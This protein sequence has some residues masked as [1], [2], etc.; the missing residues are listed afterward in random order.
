MIRSVCKQA[1]EGKEEEEEEK[2][3][4]N[5]VYLDL[6][7]GSEGERDTIHIM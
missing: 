7:I 4:L 1:Q 2:N 3:R 6:I 5:I